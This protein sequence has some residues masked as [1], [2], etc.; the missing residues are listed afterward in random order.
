MITIKTA[1]E[2]VKMRSA[3]AVAA[4]ILHAMAEYADV[5]VSTYDLD[6]FGRDLMMELGAQSASFYYHPGGRT[7]YPAYSCISLNDEVVHGIPSKSVFL[8]DGDIVSIDVAVFYNGYVGDN[9]KTVRIGNVSK[10]VDRFVR[11]AEE[12]LEL[13]IA[14]AIAGNRVGDISHAIEKH[15][16]KNRYGI[17]RD[18]VGHGVGKNMHED[19]QIPNFGP[20]G[21]GPILKPGMTLAIEP[22]FTFGSEKVFIADDGWT[23]KTVDGKL[24]VHCEHTILITETLPEIL[25]LDKK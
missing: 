12:A 10:E 20:P 1:E 17:L 19:P 13:G 23:V 4:R 7:P 22:M 15:A 2:I 14:Q 9:T 16:K 25:T 21:K 5:G 6:C 8:K 11:V 24:A 18:F 3:G